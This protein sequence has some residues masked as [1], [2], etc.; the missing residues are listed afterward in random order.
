[1]LTYSSLSFVEPIG[2]LGC[3]YALRLLHAPRLRTRDLLLSSTVRVHRKLRQAGVEAVLQVYEGQAH[4]HYLRD[5]AAPDR[6]IDAVEALTRSELL[7]LH[8]SRFAPDRLTV[9]IVGDV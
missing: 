8:A 3:I 7:T 1:M 2:A 6:L 5:P 9:V 4:A